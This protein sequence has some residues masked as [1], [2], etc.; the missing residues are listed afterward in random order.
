MQKKIEKLEQSNNL[1]EDQVKLMRKQMSNVKSSKKLLQKSLN[2]QIKINKVLEW[3]Y[4]NII[5][6]IIWLKIS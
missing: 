2:E 5:R 4:K 1:Y 3:T 6:K